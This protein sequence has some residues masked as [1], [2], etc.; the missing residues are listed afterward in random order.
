M[1]QLT[2]NTSIFNQYF[3]CMGLLERLGILYKEGLSAH[4]LSGSGGDIL[5]NLCTGGAINQ[6]NADV[7]SLLSEIQIAFS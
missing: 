5:L 4:K 6:Y 1:E 2:T 7:Q 3:K